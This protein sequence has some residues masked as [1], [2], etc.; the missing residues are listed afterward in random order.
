[1]S[2][3]QD[4]YRSVLNLGQDL[5]I[6]DGVVKEE[7]GRLIMGGVANTQYEKDQIWDKIKSI[8][9]DN[10]SD[11]VADIKVANTSYYTK[12][13]VSKGESLSLIAK[14]YFDDPMKYKTIFEANKNILNDPD[15]IH[16][17]QELTIPN[18]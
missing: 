14:K 8:A 13:T 1:M 18:L 6:Q 3:L 16:P 10:P 7:N 15:L 12:H 5:G 11:L 9:G 2:V 17:G 4:K